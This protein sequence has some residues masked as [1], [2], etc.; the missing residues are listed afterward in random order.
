MYDLVCGYA[1]LAREVSSMTR[2]LETRERE[3]ASLRQ[4]IEFVHRFLSTY[5]R[6]HQ[7][8]HIAFHS[9]HFTSLLFFQNANRVG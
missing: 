5:S 7:L 9:I 3:I 6:Q 8:L 2:L 4:I 1:Q